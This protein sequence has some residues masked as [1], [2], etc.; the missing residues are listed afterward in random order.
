MLPCLKAL[1]TCYAFT[2]DRAVGDV[3]RDILMTI[4]EKRLADVKGRNYG[5]AYSGWRHGPGHDKGKFAQAVAWV[6]DF[7]FDRF[8]H[9]Q[10]RRLAAY[11][12]ESMRLA[13]EWHEFDQAQVSNNRGVRGILTHTWWALA[14]EGDTEIP[15]AELWFQRGLI[16]AEKYLFMAHD[17]DGAPYEGPGYASVLSSITMA[18]E[19]LRRRGQAN[20]L[21]HNRFERFLEYLLYE[22]IPGGGTINNLNDCDDI[23]GSVA[24]CLPLMGTPRGR[25]LPWLAQQLDLHPSRI[26]DWG[27]R[28][29]EMI[30]PLLGEYALHFLLWWREDAPVVEPHTLGYPLSHCFRPRGVASLRTG[31]GPDDWLVSH[32]CG[33]Q[34][35]SCHRQ[36]DF[37]HVALYALGERFLVDAGYGHPR[38]DIRKPVDRFFT[39]TSS[40]NCVLIDGLNQRGVVA[41]PGWAEGE[42]LD[43]QGSPS[44]DASLGDASS[45]TGPD[46]RVRRALRRVVLARKAPRPYVAVVDVNE[47]DGKPFLAE[48]RWHTHPGNRIEINGSRFVV[49]G[50]TNDCY[51][52]VLWPRNA[53]L[54][55]ATDNGRPQ[56]RVAVRA[57]VAEMVTIF[58]P[59]CRG[60]KPPRFSCRREKE[61][62]FRIICRE[63]TATSRLHVNATLVEPLRQTRPCVIQ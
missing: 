40:H 29:D 53:T 33:R 16:A 43:F 61:G 23:C 25:L 18:A 10:R 47:K 37:N 6:Y 17:A 38:V 45:A 63:G 36:G 58:C 11:A 7:C 57:C 35:R 1:A 52:Q 28:D 49:R 8:S 30:H 41:S 42:M 59:L 24:G 20:L 60:D 3:A 5:G 34:E 46:H 31:W 26:G 2:G 50:E 12:K 39:L 62:G 13:A 15:D 9:A 4:V 51:G 55:A 48:A 21:V 56:L 27:Q 22:L 44:L 54:V 19:A 14:F 32:F